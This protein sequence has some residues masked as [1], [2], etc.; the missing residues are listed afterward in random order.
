VENNDYT[1]KFAMIE[2]YKKVITYKKMY[3]GLIESFCGIVND[4]FEYADKHKIDLPNRDRIHRN[5]EKA[6]EL[7]EY[8]IS[9]T[10]RTRSSPKH[11]H[12]NK[13]PEDVTEPNLI[14]L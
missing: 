7:I 4:L 10:D 12:P 5:M 8:R 1:I 2:E 11:E 13:T 6:M 3:E 14:I 9:M